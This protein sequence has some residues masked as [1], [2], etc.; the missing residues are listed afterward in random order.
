MRIRCCIPPLNWWGYS[1]C[2]CSG[3][4]IP[5]CLRR[6]V[7][8]SRSYSRSLRKRRLGNPERS[9]WTRR[10]SAIC[11]PTL[12]AG[13]KVVIG[14]WKTMAMSFPRKSLISAWDRVRSSLSSN[15]MEP[16]TIRP[17]GGTSLIIERR[18][19]LL[20]HPDSPTIARMSPF[21]RTRSTSRTAWTVPRG[22]GY[23]VERPLIASN[24]R[25]SP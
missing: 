20:P 13:F 12:Y 23:S 8:L 7:T 16:L 10:D 9:P 22:V 17:G 6:S 1:R 18:H 14:S 21:P 5:T 11:S 19:A 25:S 24:E 3:E 15:L 4:G 2:L